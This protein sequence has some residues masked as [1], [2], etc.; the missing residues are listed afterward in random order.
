MGGN[1]EKNLYN[2]LMEVMTRLDTVERESRH[3]IIRLNDE[4]SALKKDNCHL[5]EE[6]QLLKDDNAR[7]R[8]IINND[9]PNTSL[10]PSADQK[11]GKPTD[12][13][14][15]RQHTGRKAGGQKG[16]K[17]TTLTKAEVE[18]KIRPGK[19]RHEIRGVGDP[20][21]RKY[22]SMQIRMGNS[23]FRMNTG[24]MWFTEQM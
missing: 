4:I 21:S 6:N 7:L 5:R 10:P 19:C 3:E 14:N 9:S 11:G 18:E 16:H 22:A 15:S 1:Y 23:T 13:Y 24:V 20:S 17:G 12:A 2:Q 8:S